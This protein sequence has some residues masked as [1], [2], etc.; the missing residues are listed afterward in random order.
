MGGMLKGMATEASVPYNFSSKSNTLMTLS[1]LPGIKGFGSTT[2]LSPTVP[3]APGVPAP[4]PPMLSPYGGFATGAGYAAMQQ[5]SKAQGFGSTLVTGPLG[6]PPAQ[7]SN[8][9]LL[10]E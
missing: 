8:K 1:G 4:P 6:L 5:A 2:G 7:V 9:S 3:A 10:G